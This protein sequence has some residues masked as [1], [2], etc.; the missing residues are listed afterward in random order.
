VSLESYIKDPKL[1]K[2]L[3]IV[4]E[5]ANKNILRFWQIHAPHFVDHGETHSSNIE[6]L[7]QRIIPV[8]ILGKMTEHEIFLLTCGAWLH[9]IGMIS[10]EANESEKDVR[11]HHHTKSRLLIRRALPEIPL[12]DD[13]RYVVGEIAF[14]HRKSE[15]IDYAV[16][17]YPIQV[18]SDISK[19]RVRFLC[20][21]L[22]LADGCEIASPRSSRKLI[23]IN[24]LDEEALFHHEAHL[25]VS[26]VEFDH[27]TNEIIITARVKNSGFDT[28]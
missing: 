8:E 11:E 14:Y 12:D 3:G 27:N 4:K 15:N 13:E 16:E 19:I 21:L 18:G 2:K 28:S 25:H 23:Q 24:K 20:A 22:R 5:F 17:T 26:A 6:S 10:R 7:L 9:D 1:Q